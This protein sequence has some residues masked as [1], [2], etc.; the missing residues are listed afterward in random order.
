MFQLDD[1]FLADLGLENLPED[2]K[3][4]FLQH[5]YNELELRVGTQLSEGL[6][7][8]QLAEFEA[9]IDRKDE[10][11]TPWLQQNAP[12]Y[13]QQEAFVRLQ[14][15]LKVPADDVNLRAEYAATRWLE[16]NR[17]N[18]R[19]VVSNVLEGLKQEIGSHK[20]VLLDDN[21]AA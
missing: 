1:Q 7:D 19:D 8:E 2:Q 10:V 15:A 5:I 16:V 6:T 13:K 18:Y 11:I 9:I 4:A 20:D 17:P 14:Q 3:E 21:Q 12:D